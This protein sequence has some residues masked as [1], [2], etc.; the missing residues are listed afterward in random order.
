MKRSRWLRDAAESLI[1]SWV[2]PGV[3]GGLEVWF[4]DKG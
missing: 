2:G 1:R 4:R 3:G